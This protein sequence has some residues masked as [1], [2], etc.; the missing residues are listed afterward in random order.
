MS[1]FTITERKEPFTL[2]EVFSFIDDTYITKTDAHELKS[3]I[4][5]I[6]QAE[7]NKAID[8]MKSE[9]DSRVKDL[10]CWCKD[11]RLVGLQQADLIFDEIAEQ[12]KVGANNVNDR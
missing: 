7:R 6:I 5:D 1:D 9:W 10:I 4:V 8:D 12:M 2:D 11:C 3:R